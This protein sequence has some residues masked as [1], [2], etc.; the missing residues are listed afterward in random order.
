[1]PLIFSKLSFSA[2]PCEA[3]AHLLAPSPRSCG[4]DDRGIGAG[5]ACR[6]FCH[7]ALES[8]RS[9]RMRCHGC[10]SELRSW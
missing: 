10:Q 5:I 7:S 8:L 6:A 1:M 4:D 3:L 9:A 2:F